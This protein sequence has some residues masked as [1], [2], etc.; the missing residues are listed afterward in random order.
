MRRL[1]RP[2]VFIALAAIAVPLM[3]NTFLEDLEQVDNALKTNPSG[4]LQQS[5]ESCLN[6][7]N[8]AVVLNKMG[9]EARAR[10]ALDYC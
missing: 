6:Q 1:S 5:L 3:A 7:R 9:R 2:L 10:R 8:H 4:A